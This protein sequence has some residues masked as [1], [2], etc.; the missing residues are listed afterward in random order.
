MYS[1]NDLMVV[2]VK[3]QTRS[4]YN[5]YNN[6]FNSFSDIMITAWTAVYCKELVMGGLMMI[7]VCCVVYSFETMGYIAQ[8]SGILD[9]SYN[10]EDAVV[11]MLL[12]N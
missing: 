11:E 8:L 12:C 3:G 1:D 6:S 5:D 2:I 10:N 7:V 4:D 9:Q